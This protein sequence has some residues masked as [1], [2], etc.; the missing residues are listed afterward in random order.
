MKNE[1]QH[2]SH[3]TNIHTTTTTKFFL[4]DEDR[5]PCTKT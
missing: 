5:R 1:G 3:N 2:L 4:T